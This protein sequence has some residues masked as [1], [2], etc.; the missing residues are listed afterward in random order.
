[1]DHIWSSPKGYWRGKAPIG[2]LASVKSRKATAAN[3]LSKPAI[4]QIY[5]LTPK[6]INFSHF[7]VGVQQQIH[8]QFYEY[9]KILFRT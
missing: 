1:M 8:R 5:I 9:S 4:W 6:Q 7:D 3:W 2:K